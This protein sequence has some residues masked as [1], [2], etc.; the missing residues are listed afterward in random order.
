MW[1]F[2][3]FSE[4]VHTILM[5]SSEKRKDFHPQVC[6]HRHIEAKGGSY[7]ETIACMYDAVDLYARIVVR[8]RL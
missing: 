2:L 6:Y 8:G 4:T 5:K 1:G 3:A 7:E